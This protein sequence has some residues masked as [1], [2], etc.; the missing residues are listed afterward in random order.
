MKLDIEIKIDFNI[1][2]DIVLYMFCC[3]SGFFNFQNMTSRD[4]KIKDFNQML[5][6]YIHKLN[7][8]LQ[9]I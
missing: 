2:I 5:Y 8:N 7:P 9:Y 1:K 6:I 3:I 4:Y